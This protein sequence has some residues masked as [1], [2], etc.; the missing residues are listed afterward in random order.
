MKKSI[1]IAGAISNDP[2]YVNKFSRAEKQLRDIFNGDVINPVRETKLA[3]D[4]PESEKWETLMLFC[5]KLLSSC[6]HIYLLPDYYKSAGACIELMWAQK[7][8]LVII[9]ES[10]KEVA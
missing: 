3:F 9:R 2:D 5:L 1:Y 8:N 10:E 7:L 6:T 4:N